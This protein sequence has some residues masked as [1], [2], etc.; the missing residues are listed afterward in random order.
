MII[1][2]N[3]ETGGTAIE[4]GRLKPKMYSFVVNNSEHI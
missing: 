4:L 2:A 3:D 1:Q